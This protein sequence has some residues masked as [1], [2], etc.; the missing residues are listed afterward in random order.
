[1][2]TTEKRERGARIVLIIS[3]SL[4]IAAGALPWVA[5]FRPIPGNYFDILLVLWA[6][7]VLV[8]FGVNP[9]FGRWALFGIP[10]ALAF[11]PVAMVSCATGGGCL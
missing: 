10:V 2:A 1:M 11:I 6:A 8:C 7:S 5:R 4:S 3:L 9:R